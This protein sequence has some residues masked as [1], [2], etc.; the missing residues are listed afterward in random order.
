MCKYVYKC[1]KTVYLWGRITFFLC[2]VLVPKKGVSDCYAMYYEWLQCSK[3]VVFQS[4]ITFFCIVFASTFDLVRMVWFSVCVP[5]LLDRGHS[6]NHSM[7]SSFVHLHWN[8]LDMHHIGLLQ[9]YRGNAH[10]YGNL[11]FNEIN[12]RQDN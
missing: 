12:H 3:M 1:I 4:I 5:Y 6:G 10:H 8:Q 9:P 2:R 11:R 7:V